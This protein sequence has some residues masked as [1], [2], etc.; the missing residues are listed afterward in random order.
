MFTD[1]KYIAGY[2]LVY[3]LLC[4]V[5]MIVSATTGIG[6]AMHILIAL[7]F[8]PFGPVISAI[9]TAVHVHKKLNW[10]IPLM[11]LV[12]TSVL[13]MISVVVFVSRTGG[14]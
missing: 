6:I 9:G 5:S 3:C 11:W 8:L 12:L 4:A 13:W 10:R 14:V 1:R 7:T 2:S